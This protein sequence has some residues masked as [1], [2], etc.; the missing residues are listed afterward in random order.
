M[1]NTWMDPTISYIRDEALP[2]DKVQASKL[3]C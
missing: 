2:A 1:K 3:I